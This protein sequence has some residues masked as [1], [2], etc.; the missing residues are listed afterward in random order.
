M[1]M[2]RKSIWGTF[3]LVLLLIPFAVFAQDWRGGY[4]G[5]IQVINDWE[6]PVTVTLS[7]ER[8]GLLSSRSWTITPGQTAL[9][10]EENGTALQVR[11]RDKINVGEG[12]GGVD[13][14]S[15][16]QLQGRTWIVRVR[17]VWRST[18]QGRGRPGDRPGG[19][20]PDPPVT[21]SSYY[22]R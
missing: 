6:H 2:H 11:G 9:L 3:V 4:R 17:D 18:H 15:V 5:G 20:P 13:I 16:G 10:A 12:W 14:G 21:T 7:K 19:L 8:G 22:R 1:S